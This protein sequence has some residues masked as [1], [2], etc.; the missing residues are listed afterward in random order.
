MNTYMK[1][2]IGLVT[3]SACMALAW[4]RTPDSLSCGGSG[5]TGKTVLVGPLTTEVI[6][7]GNDLKKGKAYYVDEPLY[8]EGRRGVT[9]RKMGLERQCTD[10]RKS[11]R[12]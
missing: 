4:G 6:A 1:G 8:V 2:S 7:N 12:H 9:E 3:V 10:T 5:N 11:E